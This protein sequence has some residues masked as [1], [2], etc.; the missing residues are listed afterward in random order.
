M[1]TRARS[2]NRLGS[3]AQAQQ[4]REET[5]TEAFDR[6]LVFQPN[7]RGI[8]DHDLQDTCAAENADKSKLSLTLMK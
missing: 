4:L 8:L 3:V 6:Q 2:R 5:G 7:T 1:P